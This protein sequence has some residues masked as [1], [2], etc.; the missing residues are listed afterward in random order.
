MTKASYEGLLN[1]VLY[2][3]HLILTD[4]NRLGLLKTI[5]LFKFMFLLLIVI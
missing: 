4:R 5:K 2:L 1:I 3:S